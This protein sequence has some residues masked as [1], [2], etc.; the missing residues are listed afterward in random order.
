MSE[1]SRFELSEI[2]QCHALP[3]IDRSTRGC[4]DDCLSHATGG[5]LTQRVTHPRISWGGHRHHAPI[6]WFSSPR[7]YAWSRVGLRGTPRAVGDT[8]CKKIISFSLW[9][10]ENL[11]GLGVGAGQR[12]GLAMTAEKHPKYQG[13]DLLSVGEL[14][15]LSG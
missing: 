9:G 14:F 7:L 4:P 2:P 13:Q 15:S 11:V 1:C 10:A 12:G 5:R 3:G 8:F 6:S